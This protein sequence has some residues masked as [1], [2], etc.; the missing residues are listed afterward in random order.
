[1]SRYDKVIVRLEPRL[2]EVKRDLKPQNIVAILL[3]HLISGFAVWYAFRVGFSTANWI[4]FA[5]LFVATSF[6]VTLGYHRM[7]THRSFQCGPF[8]RVVLAIC[9]G[10]ASQ[11]SEAEWVA[12]HRVHHYFADREIDPHSPLRF[13][14]IKGL[15]WAHVGWLFFD[16]ERPLQYRRF[17]DLDSDPVVRWQERY[18]LP[19][20]LIGFVLPWLLLGWQGLLL[21]GFL[22]LA[23]TWNVGW[24]VN[25]IC[26]WIGE[27]AKDSEGR[28]YTDDDSRNN[29]VVAV[30]TFGE[31][32]HANHHVRPAWAYHGWTWYSVDASKW[33]LQGLEFFGVVWNVKKPT[34]YVRFQES[35]LIKIAS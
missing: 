22:R 33:L 28:L 3:V 4:V 17:Q 1:M 9:G 10:M 27:R 32:Y 12:N 24:S 26:H 8:L 29:F 21:S 19:I 23:L 13:P 35:K 20:V 31:G 6:G 30:F 11:G 18:Y 2:L 25:S 34:P 16:Y 15:L 5:F 14:G 7:L